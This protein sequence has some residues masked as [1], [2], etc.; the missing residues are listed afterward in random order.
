MLG[1]FDGQVQAPDC[2]VE[3]CIGMLEVVGKLGEQS[4]RQVEALLFAGGGTRAVRGE[5]GPQRQ[6]EEEK[7]GRSQSA[8]SPQYSRISRGVARGGGQRLS[9]P[10]PSGIQYLFQ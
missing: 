5:E 1:D 10:I 9:C 3:R 2:E 6:Q 7:A 4:R 8:A